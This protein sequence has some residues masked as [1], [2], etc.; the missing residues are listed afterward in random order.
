MSYYSIP[1][2]LLK[3][4]RHSVCPTLASLTNES[5]SGGI[6]PDKVK[7]AKVITLQRK[8]STD[9]PYNYRPISLLSNFSKIFEVKVMHK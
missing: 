6:F 4:L 8:G 5:F 7:I 3:M 9:N 2:N 1:C